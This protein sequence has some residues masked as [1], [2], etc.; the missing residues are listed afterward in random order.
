M[1]IEDRD[2]EIKARQ[3][4]E[5]YGCPPCY[6]PD[7]EIPLHNIPEEYQRII[8]YWQFFASRDNTELVAQLFDWERFRDFQKRVR[9]YYGK[10]KPFS[11]YVD[12]VHER[13]QQNGLK[14]DISLRS[15]LEENDRK[16]E[17][18]VEFQAY[19]VQFCIEKFEKDLCAQRERIDAIQKQA[20]SADAAVSKK[21]AE[22][23]ESSQRAWKYRERKLE[24]ERY[25]L[26]WTEQQRMAMDP[27][28]LAPVQ[29]DCD[30]KVALSKAVRGAF[31]SDHR[32]RQPKARSVL[33]EVGISK[34]KRVV[35]RQ[36][37]TTPDIAPKLA[38]L[39]MDFSTPTSD[40]SRIVDSR[41]RKPQRTKTHTPHRQPLLQK[42]SKAKWFDYANANSAAASRRRAIGQVR[43]SDAQS[44]RRTQSALVGTMTRS[45]R[46]SRPPVKLVPA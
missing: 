27:G 36:K 16:L 28:Y 12:R 29:E 42:I 40:V 3:D 1:L 13:R 10:H 20:D 8:S 34:R 2:C 43:T 26:Q 4:L 18:W 11:E 44:P 23:I 33:G 38:P 24:M 46:V 21:A 32:R 19:H 30:D 14:G 31:V 17:N 22:V 39:A 15:S 35:P 7:L 37:P 5:A 9:N 25:F 41:G 45:G 6:P